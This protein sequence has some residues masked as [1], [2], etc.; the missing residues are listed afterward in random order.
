MAAYADTSFLA[1]YFLPDANSARAL[2]GVQA[3]SG[4]LIFTALHRLEL[5]NALALAVFRGR[6]APNQARIVWQD[7]I[8]DLASGLLNATRTNWYA[9]MRHATF[10]SAQHTVNTGCRSLDVL[11]IISLWPGDW[12]GMNSL[13]LTRARGLWPRSSV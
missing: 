13:L 7:I 5:R 10:L 4:P 2:A 9:A 11:H 8:S 3:L 1:S 12:L 6:I